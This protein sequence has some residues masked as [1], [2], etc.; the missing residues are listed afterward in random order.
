MTGT[1]LTIRRYA[2]DQQEH[3]YRDDQLADPQWRHLVTVCTEW[4]YPWRHPRDMVSQA[5]LPGFGGLL[6]RCPGC[7]VWTRR[8][9]HTVV[10]RGEVFA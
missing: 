10:V 5:D 8:N 4:P 9:S 2:G 1:R 3:A 7:A 6:G